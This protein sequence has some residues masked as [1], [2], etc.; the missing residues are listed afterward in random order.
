MHDRV[1]EVA[2]LD[3]GNKSAALGMHAY[4]RR[5]CR[6]GRGGVFVSGEEVCIAVW[7]CIACRLRT[8]QICLACIAAA[9]GSA[10]ANKPGR[11]VPQRYEPLT[12]LKM[13]W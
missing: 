5:G 1:T 7:H 8:V 10:P 13:P 2:L 3:F 6:P 11:F 4:L 12:T 9:G